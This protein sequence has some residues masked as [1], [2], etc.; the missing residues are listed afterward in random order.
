MVLEQ[1]EII[2]IIKAG[3]PKFIKEAKNKQKK[4]DVHV[5]GRGVE[6]YL[7]KVEGHENKQ[8]F[9]LRLKF[10]ISNKFMISNILRPVDRV[11]SAKGGNKIYNIKGSDKTKA[12]LRDKLRNVRYGMSLPKF[13]QN[14]QSN[15]F[16]SDP[17][18]LV[19]FEV[20]PDGEDTFP[21]LKSIREIRNYKTEGRTVEWV[22]FEPEKRTNDKGEELPGEYYRFVDDEKDVVYFRDDEIVREVSDE[23]LTNNWARVPAIV[24]SDI[25]NDRLKYSDSPIDVIV[26]LADKYLRTNTIK[27]IFEFLH[28]FPFFWQYFKKCESCKGTGEITGETCPSCNGTGHSMKR[29]VSDATMLNPPK[30]KDDPTIAP[31]VA[32]YVTPPIEIPEE[33]RTELGWLWQMMSFTMWGTDYENA[34]NPTATA[35]TLNVQPQNDR[36]NHFS[37]SYEDIEKKMTDFIGEFYFPEAYEGSSISYGKRFLMEKADEVWKKYLDAKSKKAPQA[38]LTLL[39]SQYYQSEFMNDMEMLAIMTKAMR[40]EPFVHNTVAEIMNLI[41]GKILQRKIYFGE[42][43]MTLSEEY[44]VKTSTDQMVK[45]L[46]KYLEQFEEPEPEPVQ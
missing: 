31:D 5:N 14:V 32:G 45:D 44:V 17:A 7:H 20:T 2:Q 30:K 23:A 33:Q 16:Y 29:D 18:G 42:W 38:T 37:D 40:V 21:D 3:T 22:L 35:A 28:G 26:E 15:K 39:L 13:I 8:Q 46:D 4:L 43:W 9:E 25:L 1:E 19:F 11:F 27:S 10:A 34:E 12:A 36:L 24:N 6:K 41:D